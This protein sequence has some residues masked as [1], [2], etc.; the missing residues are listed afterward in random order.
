MLRQDSA[1]PVYDPDR[2]WDFTDWHIELVEESAGICLG[3]ARFDELGK[4]C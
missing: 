3:R 4:L 1:P 2:I